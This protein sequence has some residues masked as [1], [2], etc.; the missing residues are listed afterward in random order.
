MKK[1]SVS[2]S[3]LWKTRSSGFT[4]GIL[5]EGKRILFISGQSGIDRS[6]KV[7]KGGFETQCKLAFQN[8]ETILKTA[9]A[10]FDNVVKVNGF[11]TDMSNLPV[12]GRIASR[13][14]KSEKPAQTLVE[15]TRL[16]RPEMLVEV[17]AIAVL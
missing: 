11:L 2:P 1:N 6:A 8:I 12:Y 13:Y 16:A 3:G 10:E 15:V 5:V 17:E 4:H 7:V 9:N 14:F